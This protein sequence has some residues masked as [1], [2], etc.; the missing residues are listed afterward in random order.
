MKHCKISKL[1]NDWSVSKFFTKKWIEINDLS[2][3]QFSASKNMRF[4][5]SM[6]RSD[7]CGYSDAYIVVK[8][9]TSVRDTNDTNK[10]VKANFQE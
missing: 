5:T 1:L 8:G 3:G 9:R 2:N 6:L 7:L 10:K 4:K